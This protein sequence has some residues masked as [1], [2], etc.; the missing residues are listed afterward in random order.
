MTDKCVL[1]LD[2]PENCD[3]CPCSND[4][5]CKIKGLTVPDDIMKP[6]WCPL[7]FLDAKSLVD[8]FTVHMNPI[9]PIEYI[10]RNSAR[11]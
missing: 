10:K 11:G 2:T 7:I 6:E 5:V 3:T 1:F 9:D 4:G 8:P